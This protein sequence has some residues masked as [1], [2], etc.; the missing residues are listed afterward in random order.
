MS[1]RRKFAVG[2]ILVFVAASA[3]AVPIVQT[4][5][6]QVSQSNYTYYMTDMLYTSLGDDRGFG[7]EHDLARDNIYSHFA[8]LGLDVSYQPFE[9]AGSTYSNVVGIHRGTVRPDDIYIVGAHFDSVNNPGADDNASGTAGVMEAARVLSQYA[10]EATLVFIG[11][12]R[13]EQWLV[14]SRAYANAHAADNILGMISLDMIAYNGTASGKAS[15][16]GGTGSAALTQALA[17]AF[18]S[19]GNGLTGI[20]RGTLY[21]YASDHVPFADAGFQACLLIEYDHLLNPYYHTLQDST[22]TPGY[23]DYVYATN[24]VG[25]VTGFLAESAVLI[26]EPTTILL[27]ALGC[28]I[29]RRRHT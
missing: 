1:F 23:I 19:Y 10:F 20:D 17:G 29:L 22:D 13:E 18:D 5:V 12:D 27:L 3:Q 16:Y 26:P 21:G 11:F 2:L 25:A 6:S 15:I 14:G 24:I 9:Y 7:T 28:M 8:G 4:V